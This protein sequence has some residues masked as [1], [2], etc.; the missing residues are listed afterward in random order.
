MSIALSDQTGMYV[1]VAIS[2]KKG[3]GTEPPAV[4]DRELI[5]LLLAIDGAGSVSEA[6]EQVNRSTRQAQR[7]LKRFS[8]GS[9]L[10]PLKHHG[11]K[12]TMLS[13]EARQCIALYVALRQCAE[14]LLRESPSVR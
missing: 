14:Q 6:C 5:D 9:G 11:R 7:L 10:R 4:I 13:D 3:N 2:L 1:D 8:D 12:G